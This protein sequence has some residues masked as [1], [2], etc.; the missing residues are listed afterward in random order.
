MSGARIVDNWLTWTLELRDHAYSLISASFCVFQLR[1]EQPNGLTM[2]S[3]AA[4]CRLPRALI[5][6]VDRMLAHTVR[7]STNRLSANMESI[8]GYDVTDCNNQ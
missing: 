7:G 6:D 5:D 3:D 8:S 1:T 4:A 2:L